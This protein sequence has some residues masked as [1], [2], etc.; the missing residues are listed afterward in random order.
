MHLV[1]PRKFCI[2][3]PGFPGYYS[4]LKRNWRQWFCKIYGVDKVHYGLGEKQFIIKWISSMIYVF[5]GFWST[6]NTKLR[7]QGKAPAIWAFSLSV[8]FPLPFWYKNKN[9]L[10]TFSKVSSLNHKI[11]DNSMEPWS[12]IVKS[13]PVLL[14][15]FSPKKQVQN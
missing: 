7:K 13:L 10:N 9:I 6:C 14:K 8:P 15:P 4:S 5:V 2:L 11:H 12:F 3:F 1:Y